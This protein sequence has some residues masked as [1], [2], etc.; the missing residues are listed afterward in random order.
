[1][2]N[3][4]TLNISKISTGV[5]GFDDLFYGGLR[6]PGWKNDGNIRDGICIVIYGDR[7]ISK[8]DLAMQIMRGVDEYFQKLY[9]KDSKMSPR[10][11]TLNH[12]ESELRKKYV[13][14]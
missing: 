6:L 12:R 1:M 8:S 3:D 10:Y 4:K 9:G 7:G 5:P 11:R 14:S 13:H 2:A